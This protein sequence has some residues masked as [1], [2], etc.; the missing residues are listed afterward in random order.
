M[1]ATAERRFTEELLP[2][3]VN[4]SLSATERQHVQD[5]V[6]ADADLSREADV[7]QGIRAQMQ[8]EASAYSP[9]EF[10]LARLMR[11]IDAEA[12]VVA[13]AA[14]TR[15]PA[16][17]AMA[18][19]VALV[20]VVTGSIVTRPGSEAPVY[21]EQASGDAGEATLTIAFR[22]DATQADMTALLLDFGLV[23]VDGPSA[24]GLYRVA[25][26][27]DTDLDALAARLAG[28]TEIVETVDNLQ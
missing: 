1:T 5:A 26:L 16:F 14:T 10:G 7:L 21:Y 22:P 6:A 4:G 8:S 3:F 15:R 2:F 20:A 25:P 13:P 17:A 19:A 9:G 11:D 18:A 23:V 27:D 28:E 24:L 12:P